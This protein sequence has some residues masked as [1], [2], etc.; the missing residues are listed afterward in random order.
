MALP[1]PPADKVAATV[2]NPDRAVVERPLLEWIKIV[3]TIS[4]EAP[5][6]I[7]LRSTDHEYRSDDRDIEFFNG[8]KCHHSVD[9]LPYNL[10]DR[11]HV[12]F[13]KDILA[14]YFAIVDKKI[15]RHGK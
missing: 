3:N 7:R 5:W 15:Q 13:L 11:E 12:T 9:S 2:V 4:K 1:E 8:K 14:C 6:A 10:E